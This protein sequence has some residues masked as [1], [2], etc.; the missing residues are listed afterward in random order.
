[1][2]ISGSSL[3]TSVV[4]IN[5]DLIAENRSLRAPILNNGRWYWRVRAR[6]ANGTWGPWSAVG[7]YVVIAPAP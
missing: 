6:R 2:Q 1:V 7:S 5:D 4:Y 3:F